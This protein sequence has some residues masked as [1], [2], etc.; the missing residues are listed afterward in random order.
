MIDLS[1]HNIAHR[2]TYHYHQQQQHRLCRCRCRC[3]R[4]LW[5]GP[6]WVVLRV[7]TGCQPSLFCADR[8]RVVRS[9]EANACIHSLPTKTNISNTHR[10]YKQSDRCS[11][12]MLSLPKFPYSLERTR[13]DSIR[14]PSENMGPLWAPWG[15]VGRD[16]TQKSTYSC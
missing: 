15:H 14:V 5:L 3:R 12:S 8:S 1:I 16:T 7:T 4:H 9:H 6:T 13:M 10:L 11:D 2:P